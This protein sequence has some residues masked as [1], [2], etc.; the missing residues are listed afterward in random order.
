MAEHILVNRARVPLIFIRPSLVGA[1]KEEP[2]PGWVDSLGY[3]NG[4][5]L[6]FGLGQLKD[7]TGSMTNIGDLIPVDIV[8]N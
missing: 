3:A 2:V 5:L 6:Q 7:I 8:A 1:S 4:V